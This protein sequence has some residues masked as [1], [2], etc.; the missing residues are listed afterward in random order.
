MISVDPRPDNTLSTLKE[1]GSSK[2]GT[3][4]S[5]QEPRGQ[6]EPVHVQERA[7]RD[8]VDLSGEGQKIVNL[9]RV[10]ELGDDI[11]NA[12]VDISFA[13]RLREASEDILRINELFRQTVRS[14]FEWWRR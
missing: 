3:T 12:S 11:R 2:D 13:D 4:V 10:D 5:D 6:G 14:V 7:I 9:N 1:S 8:T